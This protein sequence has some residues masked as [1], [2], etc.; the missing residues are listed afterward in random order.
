MTLAICAISV[1]LV[2]VALY[3]AVEL[4]RHCNDRRLP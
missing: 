1:A 2:L 4:I 3:G